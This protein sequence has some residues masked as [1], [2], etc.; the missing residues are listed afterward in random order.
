MRFAEQHDHYVAI[1]VADSAVRV[2]EAR[3][4]ASS[5]ST[6]GP[7]W[8]ALA[9]KIAAVI[10]GTFDPSWEDSRAVIAAAGALVAERRIRA[11]GAVDIDVTDQDQFS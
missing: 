3:D 1:V 10:A 7:E 9:D 2:L 11:A 4:P 5:D 6:A 8:E